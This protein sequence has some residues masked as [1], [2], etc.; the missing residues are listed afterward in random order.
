[1][2]D[3]EKEQLKEKGIII[4]KAGDPKG[5]GPS[6]WSIPKKATPNSMIQV[7]NI[8]IPTDNGY[9]IMQEME[10]IEACELGGGDP[11]PLPQP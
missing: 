7:G 9:Q 11:F 6:N 3:K 4:E 10:D 2:V 1:M 8:Q 5:S